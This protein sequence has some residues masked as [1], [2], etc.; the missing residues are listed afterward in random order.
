MTTKLHLKCPVCGSADVF[1]SCEPKCCFNHVCGDCRSTFEPVTQPAGGQ[2]RIAPPEDLPDPT[3]PAVACCRCES[4]A[5][6][7]DEDGALVCADC[8]T[9]MTMELTEI[10]GTSPS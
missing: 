3:D 6:Y 10:S 8:G 4:V 9:V 1:Y 5:V 7:V 2:R